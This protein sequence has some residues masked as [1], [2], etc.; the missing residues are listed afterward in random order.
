MPPYSG[1]LPRNFLLLSESGS[2]AEAIPKMSSKKRLLAEILCA[3][4]NEW[5]RQEVERTLQQLGSRSALSEEA[6][7]GHGPKHIQGETRRDNSA[8]GYAVKFAA[9]TENKDLIVQLANR[10]DAK[11]FLPTLRDV[12]MFLSKRG[13]EGLHFK[14]RSDSFRKVFDVLAASSRDTLQKIVN[15]GVYFGP[16]RLGPLS[17]AIKATGESIRGAGHPKEKPPKK[18]KKV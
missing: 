1:I 9:G 3:L 11:T 7:A 2:K 16:S 6:G 18:S 13:A 14:S 4:I 5:G 10:F 17:D 15:E 8:T 12:S